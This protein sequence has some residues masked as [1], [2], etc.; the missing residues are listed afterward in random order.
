M[1]ASSPNLLAASDSGSDH[2]KQPSSHASPASANAIKTS[3]FTPT[4]FQQLIR[5]L[6]HMLQFAVAYF[7][8]LLAMYYN[9][10]IIICI[11]IGAFIGYFVSSWHTITLP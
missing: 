9:G 4:V 5:A 6:L 2:Y 8:M 7:I 3:R 10:Y 1:R 11:F